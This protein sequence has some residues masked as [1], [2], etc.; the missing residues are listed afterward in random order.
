MNQPIIKLVLKYSSRDDIFPLFSIQITTVYN[1]YI[2]LIQLFIDIM[3]FLSQYQSTSEEDLN[4]SD[5]GNEAEEMTISKHA[6]RQVYLLTLSQAPMLLV[7]T[8]Q[9]FADAVLAAYETVNAEII[10]WCV[11]KESHK[12]H[13]YHYHMA[14]KGDRSHRW[15]PIAN[16]LRNHRDLRV[17]FSST[18]VNYYSAYLYVTKEDPSPLHSTSHPDLSNGPPRTTAASRT[19]V[20]QSRAGNSSSQRDGESSDSEV[21]PPPAKHQ[22]LSTKKSKKLQPS[23][24][25]D[26]IVPRNI[27]T[28]QELLVFAKSQKDEGK[29]DLWDF[30][31]NRSSRVVNDAIQSAWSIENELEKTR[32]KQ[33]GRIGIL[34]TFLQKECSHQCNGRWLEMAKQILDSNGIDQDNFA[35]IIYSALNLGRRKNNNIFIY[36]PANCGK[37]FLLKPLNDIYKT[38]TNPAKGTYAWV[39]IEKAEVVFLND[40]RW[41]AELIPWNELLLMLE[42]EQISIPAPKSHF[43]QDL[44]LVE[45]CA[46]FATSKYPLLFL[47]GGS[48]DERETDMMNARWI[49]IELSS[50]ISRENQI[51]I[52]PC[53]HCFSVLI[54]EHLF[55]E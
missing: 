19:R 14:V 40:F 37:S 18:H 46:I 45:H 15:L 29:K 30:C 20:M 23:D 36:G 4:S 21:V 25:Y 7:P 39:G 10:H 47:R 53:A 16:F 35:G 26:I 38:F 12:H 31:F 54:L 5:S 9:A 13:G 34:E 27:H 42:G 28:K 1:I 33:L 55:E 2:A 49:Y 52:S 24:I 44:R 22:K 43:E 51:D 32:R 41:T 11:S 17:H 50:Q 3:E 6:N 8:R 48:V